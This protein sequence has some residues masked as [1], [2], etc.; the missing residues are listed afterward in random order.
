MKKLILMRHAKSDWNHANLSD[1]QRPLNP[2][3]KKD[4]LR[5][6]ALLQAEG[7][8]IDAIFC[9]T[10][11]RTRETLALL[12]EEYTF[13]GE[14]Q[15]L[16]KLYEADLHT[17]LDV[18]AALPANVETAMLLGHNPTMS[19]ALEFFTD[20]FEPFKTAD[21]ATIEFD[22]DDWN[23]LIEKPEGKL[24]GYWTPKEI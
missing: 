23:T 15:F 6:G 11:Q 2:R 24:V 22:V 19:A 20:S 5:M 14:A 4:A 21:I 12:L 9:S 16:R 8:E 7:I 1:H 13:E 17:Y 10:A 18:L 3:G